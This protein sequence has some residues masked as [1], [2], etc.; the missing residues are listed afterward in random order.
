MGEDRVH[1]LKCWPEYFGA[2]RTGA[3]RF[4]WRWNDRGFATGDILRLREWAPLGE[5]YTGREV[6]VRV[7]Y[8]LADT[9][10]MGPPIGYC[11]MSI[12]PAAKAPSDW[13]ATLTNAEIGVLWT[14]TNSE[15]KSHRLCLTNADRATAD[16]L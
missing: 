2:I 1:E 12:E 3:K 8:L 7:T 5:C 4:E 6:S 13:P 9:A 10:P 16:D 14:L 15:V 11:V